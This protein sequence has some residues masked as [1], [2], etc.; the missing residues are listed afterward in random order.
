M[1][2]CPLRRLVYVSPPLYIDFCGLFAR[3]C[4]APTRL[5]GP[6]LYIDFCGLFPRLW[7]R[8]RL[9]LRRLPLYIDFRGLFTEV[10]SIYQRFAA[11]VRT[12]IPH[13]FVCSVLILVSIS[14]EHLRGV[15]AEEGTLAHFLVPAR[16]LKMASPSEKYIQDLL[17]RAVLGDERTVDTPMELN[18]KLRPT[19]GDPL[20]DP[21]RYRHLVGSLVYL[22]VTRPDIS[23]PVHIV[24]QLS[25]L[26]PLFTI[27]IFS[28]FFVTFVTRSLVAFS[29]PFQL[30]P[31][32][33]LFGCYVGE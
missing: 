29:F 17:A 3:F 33:V 12:R 14:P 32:P 26:L 18:V 27:V 15:L 25:Q 2:L 4:R 16:M 9:C 10:L 23:Y 1:R 11:M 19:D 30:S 7:P 31:A 8:R 21:T 20:P 28:V 24:S 13:P 6:P 5:V 22:L